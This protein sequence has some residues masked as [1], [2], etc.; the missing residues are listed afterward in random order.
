MTNPVAKR[1]TPDEVVKLDK[2][3]DW[4]LCPLQANNYGIQF[5]NFQIRN[6][7]SGN[8]LF[9]VD[10]HDPPPQAVGPRRPIPSWAKP[11][12]GFTLDSEQA[13][14]TIHYTFP[15]SVLDAK[16]IG[17]KLIFSIGPRPVRKFRM[18]ERHYFKERL[19]KTFDFTF[20][21][22]IP[23]SKNSWEAI[24]QVPAD[25]S[26]ELKEA[27]VSEPYETR[28]DSFYFVGDELI[29]HNKAEYRYA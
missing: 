24:Y 1:W 7:D 22:C 25:L 16:T 17:T 20:D 15:R 9:S 29:M 14:R 11:S 2:P 3:T 27:M 23:G 8:I 18:I 6:V 26:A 12:P 28:S 4:F 21:F 5:L 10:C 13:G 19:L